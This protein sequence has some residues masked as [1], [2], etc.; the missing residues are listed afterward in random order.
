MRIDLRLLLIAALLWPVSGARAQPRANLQPEPT[1]N[2]KMEVGQTRLIRISTKV[3][4]VSVAD[5]TVS[6]VQVVTTE[7]VLITAK[8]VGYTHLILWDANNNPLVIAISV[9]RNLDQLRVQ[10][11][12]LFPNENIQVSA[13]GDM[14]VLSGTVS[15]LRTP[16]RAAE[17]AKQYTEKLANLIQVSGDE[18]VQLE[19]KFAEVSR[20]GMRKAGINFLWQD[21]ERGY[22]GG[23]STNSTTPGSYYRQ[24]PTPWVPGTDNAMGYKAPAVPQASSTDAFNL[25][26]STGLSNFPFSAI[27]SILSQEGLAKVLAE[28]TLVALSGQKAE[29]HAG[30]EVPILMS[31]QLGQVSMQ[32]KK[33]GVKL[34]FT[35][36]VLSERTL[37]LNLGLEVSEIDASAGVTS[38][39]FQVP[40]FKTRSSETTIRLKDGQSFAIAGLLSDSV[41]SIASKVPVLGDLPILGLLFSSKSY[42]RNETE[43]MMVVTAHLVRPLT[44][45]ETPLLP[46]EDEYND[47]SDFELFLLGSIESDK[48]ESKKNSNEKTRVDENVKT[49]IQ[50]DAA[51]SAPRPHA[52]PPKDKALLGKEPAPSNP[53]PV[54]EKLRE[55]EELEG[56]LGP[57]GFVRS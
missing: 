41:R 43:L 49:E 13:V 50:V 52:E 42:Q 18:Q 9:T 39:G 31:T 6:D 20:T 7:Q 16:A 34:N 51:L 5:A 10:Y 24:T 38:T 35:P 36:T 55:P 15:D 26:F 32:F 45:D 17:V 33:F 47:P 28:P 14:V 53:A 22:V 57:I 37:S 23:Q 11:T 40:G 44:P 27:L 25:F 29:F 21:N 4:R 19:V 56:P 30:G 1:Q 12:E 54:V 3:I 46:G 48:V 8:S 2:L